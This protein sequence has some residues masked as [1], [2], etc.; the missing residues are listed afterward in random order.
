[1][2]R[3]GMHMTKM[4]ILVY[5]CTDPKS[6]H[7]EFSW[8]TNFEQWEAN[9]LYFSIHWYRPLCQTWINFLFSGRGTREKM[10]FFKLFVLPVLTKKEDI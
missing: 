8:L 4:N 3:K 10:A 7:L 2:H 6:R 9:W 1:M 5:I